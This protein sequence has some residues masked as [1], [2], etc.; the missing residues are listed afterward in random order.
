[1][2]TIINSYQFSIFPHEQVVTLIHVQFPY[3]VVSDRDIDIGGVIAGVL[4][5]EPIQKINDEW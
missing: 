1:M 2:K 4:V 5:R 3:T